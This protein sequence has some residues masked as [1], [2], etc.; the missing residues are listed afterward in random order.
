MILRSEY[1]SP[2]VKRRIY[3]LADVTIN[4]EYSKF[5]ELEIIMGDRSAICTRWKKRDIKMTRLS[6]RK[7]E[8]ER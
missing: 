1:I 2:V 4:D 5:P 8:L 6:L 3:S 7:T